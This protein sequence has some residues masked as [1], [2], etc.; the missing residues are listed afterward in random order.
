MCGSRDLHI[1]DLHISHD[2]LLSFSVISGN[3]FSREALCCD[4]N[5][6]NYSV[7]YYYYYYYYL[8]TSVLW[9]LK[10]N[11]QPLS[12]YL[13]G[14]VLAFVCVCVCVCVCECV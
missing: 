1:S 4:N 14:S 7:Y 8:L 5:Q 3:E 9:C 6:M 2:W 13:R 11:W 12:V 10:T